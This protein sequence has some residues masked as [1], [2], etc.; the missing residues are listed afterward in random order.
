M[1]SRR[2]TSS[3]IAVPPRQDELRREM[4]E[5]FR[6][7]YDGVTLEAF[8]RDLEGKE[9]V[10]VLRD[11]DGILRGFSTVR[12]FELAVDG[13]PL[14]LL[15]SGDTI[16]EHGWWGDQALGRAW[17]VL[18]G[19]IRAQSPLPLYWLLLSK[20]HRTYLYLPLF[21]HEFYPRHDAPPPAREKAIIDA[22]ASR[23]YGSDY[24]PIRGVVAFA[25]APGRLREDLADVG[26]HR[27]RNEHVRF[28]L[29]ANPHY[30][31]GHELVC[32]AP[33]EA[34]NMKLFARQCFER[35]LSTPQ[36]ATA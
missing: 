33:L 24:D 10:I 6:R 9:H 11:G 17:S 28:F 20:G 30:A 31:D 19:S 2:L 32:L 13:E 8:S 18:A 26:A 29:A 7:H 35:G 3:C 15:F 23:K 36:E 16:I 25:A 21:F 5:L 27:L 12:T 34:E 1:S 22:F 14:R 4:F